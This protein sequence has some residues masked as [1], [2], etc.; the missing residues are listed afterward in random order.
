[1]KRL[2]YIL[3]PLTIIV[4][5]G[6]FISC[7]FLLPAPLGRNNPYDDEAQIGRFNATVSGSDSIVTSWD[8]RDALPEIDDK[9]II[10]KIRIVHSEGSRPASKYPINPEEVQEY[11]SN[12]EW[13][14]NWTGLTQDREHYFALYA[15]EKGGMWL[16]PKYT[17]KYLDSF[18]QEN[19]VTLWP[20][21]PPNNWDQFR[22][23][24]ALNP[25]STTP[26]VT[27]SGGYNWNAGSFLV[28]EFYSKE[29][30]YFDQFLLHLQNLVPGGDVDLTIYALKKDFLQLI[31]WADMISDDTIDYDSA[32]SR[33]VTI[34]GGGNQAIDISEVVNRMSLH[35][36]R[37]I[38]ILVNTGSLSVDILNWS[39]DAHFWGYN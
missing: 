10:D 25:P 34:I 23:Y 7:D 26:D 19:F 32:I 1:M 36:S 37:S 15:H 30:K 31:D 28:L 39:I 18:P 2:W 22:V 13:Q 8:W 11:T 20:N 9:R 35:Y 3:V 12:I 21:S 14:F 16:A 5:T 24:E 27:N 6:F 4:F 29:A 38:A 33:Q 17:E